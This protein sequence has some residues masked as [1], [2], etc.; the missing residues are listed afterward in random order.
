M[1]LN[2]P[3][4]EFRY[5]KGGDG[6]KT[7]IF[8]KLRRKFVALTPE[9]WVRQNFVAY[10]IKYKA[11]PAG[12]IANE[13]ALMQ[14][15]IK[16]RCDT[17]VLTRQGEPLMIIEYKAATVKITQDVF[18]QILRYNSV[19][20][21]KYLIVTNGMVHYCCQ[22]SEDSAEYIFIGDIPEYSQL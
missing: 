5:K 21:A 14:N 12:L 11:Y 17:V 3:T 15:G 7:Q 4:E 18:N 8:D 20:R 2:I 16:R 19:L 22:L 6:D 9:E 13:M 1:Q 10:L